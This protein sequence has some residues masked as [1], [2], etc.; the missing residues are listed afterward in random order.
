[1]RKVQDFYF[2]KAKKEKYPARSVYKLEEAQQK[3]RLLGPGDRV[4]DL[5]CQPGSWSLY[6]AK[7]IGPQG[8]VVG[9]D[10]ATT[11]N[12]VAGPGM[13]ALHILSGDVMTPEAVEAVKGFAS[14]YQ[15]VLSD[16]A[17]RT[18]GNKLVDHHKS[19]ALSRRAFKIAEQVLEAE[20]NFYCKVFQGEDVD[21]FVA[22]VKKRFQQ[23]KILK[24]RSS[25]VE[26][27]EVFVLG[28]GFRA[29]E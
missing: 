24:P 4:L 22:E 19:L 1:M 11:T 12:I 25:R 2:H 9:L 18:T 6:A 5:G 27:R 29:E 28:M 17:S 20:G 3:Y 13:G 14:S 26:S 23:V 8:M 10:L 7:V 16:L 21:D 15:V